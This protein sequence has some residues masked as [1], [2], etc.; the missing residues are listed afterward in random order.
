V[1]EKNLSTTSLAKRVADAI[2]AVV[3]V[4]L[5]IAS[6]TVIIG[7]IIYAFGGYVYGFGG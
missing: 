1:K 6:A 4:L 5:I 7:G 3:A 2:P